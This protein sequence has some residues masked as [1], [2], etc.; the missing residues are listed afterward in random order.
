MKCQL[1]ALPRVPFPCNLSLLR[2]AGLEKIRQ[3]DVQLERQIYQGVVKVVI[4]NLDSAMKSVDPSVSTRSFIYVPTE[5][6]EGTK[7]TS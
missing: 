6:E 4:P 7:G 2:G 1:E 3:R 5:A